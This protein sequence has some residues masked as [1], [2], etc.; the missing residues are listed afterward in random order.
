MDLR[1]AGVTVHALEDLS[2]APGATVQRYGGDDPGLVLGERALEALEQLQRDCRFDLV[3]FPDSGALGMRAVQAK[4]SGDALGAV[5]IAVRLEDPG[6]WRRT[7][8]ARQIAAPRELKLDYCQR[9]A[10]EH[11]D[12]RLSASAELLERASR[13]GWDAAGAEVPI[14]PSLPA[15]E[16]GLEELY[17]G[18]AERRAGRGLVTERAT[19][20]VAVAHYNHDR[21]LADALASLAAQTRTADE[22]IVIDDGST[23][24]AALRVFRE[25]EALYPDWRFLRQENAGPGRARNR[26]L[27]QASGS[28]FLAFD[29]DNIAEPTLLARLVR[30]MEL[31]PSR[32]ATSCHNLAFTDGTDITTGPFAFRYSPTGGPRVLA[33]VENVYGDTCSIFRTEALRSVGGF[34]AARWSPTEDWM[35]FVK[36]A[37]RDFEID[38][39]PRPLFYYRTESGGRLEVVGTD[40]A[41]K[42][43]LGAH[44]LDEFFD[45]AELTRRERRELLESLQAFE[46]AVSEGFEARL[47]E[48][49]QL[50]DGLRAD[51]DAFRESQ[52]EEVRGHLNAQREAETARADAAE[53]ERDELARATSGWLIGKMVRWRMK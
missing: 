8:E 11:A 13:A 27:E 34:E 43:R 15:D 41:T 52:L 26:A 5:A 29:S 28:V 47:S 45:G 17:R 21:Y 7:V 33:C 38:V 23:S 31:N 4:R 48:Q 50:H 40:R 20:T 35:T 53:R 46:A 42:L 25:Q 22:V 36:M 19:I 2:N 44:L 32:A 49:R 24:E 14:V 12:V 51:L 30:A 1:T 6:F 9:Y 3:E 39:L 10:F 16:A 37:V 18:F